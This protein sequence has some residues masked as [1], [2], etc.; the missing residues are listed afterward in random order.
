M[1][2]VEELKEEH[3]AVLAD[4]QVADVVH[5]EQGRMSQHAQPTGELACGRGIDERLDKRSQGLVVD[6]A[7]GF[8]RGDGQA[9][10]QMRFPDSGRPS[11][12]CPLPRW[13]I[14]IR[15]PFHPCAD[16]TV[17]NLRK[18][19]ETSLLLHLSESFDRNSPTG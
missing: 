18:T 17:G 1:A 7:S 13:G 5:H 3:G 2:G 11:T 14:T 15:Y 9:Y 8:G 12:Y 6:A 10:G 19:I 4:A 16:E